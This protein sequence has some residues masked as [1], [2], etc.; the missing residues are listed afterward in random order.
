MGQKKSEQRREEILDALLATMAE[1]GYA[2][3]TI[4]RIAEQAGLTSGL[5]HYHFQSKQAILVALTERMVEAQVAMLHREVS[6][7]EQAPD[8]LRAL[9]DAFL[10]VGASAN[11]EA[12]AAWVTIGAEAIRQPE[13]NEQFSHALHVFGEEI[14]TIID[15]GVAAG[16]FDAAPMSSAAAAAAILATIQGYFTVAATARD[17]IP[18]GTAADATWRMVQGLLGFSSAD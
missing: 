10:A 11:P 6:G 2:K 15:L 3:A 4:A 9:I 16:D 12:V 14:Q 17:L 13:I 1:R 7:K 5:L 18:R 8:K